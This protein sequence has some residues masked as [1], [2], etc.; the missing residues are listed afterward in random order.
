MGGGHVYLN[1]GLSLSE[2]EKRRALPLDDT[3]LKALVLG[4]TVEVHKLVSGQRVT[5]IGGTS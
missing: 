3:Q 5:D 1:R 4:K 2:L